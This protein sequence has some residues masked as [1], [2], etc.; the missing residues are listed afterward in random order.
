MVC[1][2][3]PT[4]CSADSVF[5]L[6]D[7]EGRSRKGFLTLHDIYDL[8][9][10]ADLVVLSACKSG[11]GTD[12]RGEGLVGLTRGFMSAGAR[13]IVASLW[14]VDDLAG[15]EL[16]KRFYT[17]LLIGREKPAAALR[18][19]QLEMLHQKRWSAP[20]YWA[21]FVLHGDWN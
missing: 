6:V 11:I 15:A 4:R 20:Y 7:E 10:N 2:I 16:M 18:S 21:G 3:L 13:R 8:K 9:L 14:N 19:A 12:L 5:S 17:H 1:L